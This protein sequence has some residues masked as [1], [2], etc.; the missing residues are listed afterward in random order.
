MAT[1]RPFSYNTGSLI[2]GTIQIG[3]LAIGYPTEGFESTGLQWWEG[4]DE[5]LGYVIAKPI[6]AG[7]QPNPLG[8]S[9]SIAFSR[10]TSLNEASFISVVNNLGGQSFTSGNQAKTWLNANGFWTSYENIITNGLKLQLDA[11]NISSYPGTGTTWYDISGNG[12]N[13]DMQNSS[14]I[15]WTYGGIGYF[16]TGSNGWFTKSSTSGLPTGNS[17]YTLSVWVKLGSSWS[18]QGMMSIG[19]F[20]S[21]NQANAFRTG[22]TNQIIN[23]WWAN[24]L[25]V[26]SSVSPANSWFNAVV[27]YDGT[28]RRILING[29]SVGSDT[30]VGHSVTSGT[31]QIAK[32]A[33]SEYLN[34]NISQALIYNVALS[35]S[36]IL[37][38][39]NSTKSRFGL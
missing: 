30:P 37:Q 3:D 5:D 8:V 13:V 17:P 24:D 6:P 12:N 19:P 16:T 14:S 10:S 9:A 39:F 21:S 26:T 33:G 1:S 38:N 4:P 29:S 23:Y 15:S 18:G 31:L 32:T 25:V 35:D 7:N 28:T 11:G 20:G 27:K 22:N 2:P 34:G 36:E